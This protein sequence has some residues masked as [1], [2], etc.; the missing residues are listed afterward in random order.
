MYYRHSGYP[1]GLKKRTLD[2][3]LE[4]RPEEVIRLAVRG[5]LPKNRL[6]RK[7][8]TKL[9]IYAGPEHPH[10]A[11]KPHEAG[12]HHP[13]TDEKQGEVNEPDEIAAEDAVGAQETPTPR[14]QAREQAIADEPVAESEQ[15][16]AEASRRAR[17]GARP[18]RRRRAADRRPRPGRRG[19]GRLRRGDPARQAGD[20]RHGPRGRHRPRGRGGPARRETRSDDEDGDGDAADEDLT[21]PIADAAIDLAAG[22]R[23][24][25]TGKRKT[26]VARVILKPGTG[27]YTIN[28]RTLDEFFPRPA[29]QRTIRQAL[30]TVALEEK[31]DVVAS[32]HGGGVSAQA[33]ALRHGISARARRRGP[34]PALRAQA[35]RLPHARRAREGAQEGR[36]QEGPQAAAVL[37]A[38]SAAWRARSSAP[39]VSG[40]SRASS[41]TAEL[42]ARARPRRHRSALGADAPRV[43][44]IRDTRESGEMLEAAVAAGVAA[45]GGEALLGGVLPTPGRAAA[46]RPPRARPRRRALRLAQP[47]PRQRHQVLRRRRLQALRRR[48]AGDR[49]RARRARRAARRD[50]PRAA[51]RTARWRTTCARCTSASRG[52]DLSGRRI[53]L[54]CANGPTYRAAPEIFRRL[55]A[56]V[57]VLA[58]APTAATSTRAAAPRT[59]RR[60]P[61][62]SREGGHDAGFAFDGDGDRVLAVDRAGAVV[63]GD[64]LIALA[65]LHLRAQGRLPGGG[66]AVTVMTNY[67]FHTA[68]RDA[69]GGGRD[70][71]GRRPLRA[72]GAARARLGAGR[73]AVGPH[74][75]HGLRPVG[76]RHRRGAADARGAR[77]AATWPTAHAMEKLPQRLVNVRLADRAALA[78]AVEADRRRGRRA[79]RGARAGRGRVLVRASGTEPL[80]RVMVEAPT[81]EEADAVCG[82]LSPPSRP[83]APRSGPRSGARRIPRIRRQARPATGQRRGPLEGL[84]RPALEFEL[85]GGPRQGPLLVERRPERMCGIV[86]YSGER[87]AQDIVLAGLE[88]LEYRGYDSAGIS[89]VV[90]RPAWTPSAPSAT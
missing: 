24:S 63:D 70:H 15:R 39:T 6:A 28:G 44:V 83:T 84:R 26:A 29:L 2:E 81:A 21:Q 4:R 65:A 48:R 5:M 90:R 89:L 42:A 76:R 57:D 27:A 59:S 43:L 88:K 56:D 7:Q 37:E 87:A 60:S 3:M 22:A 20:P 78:A 47:V 66:V 82:R 49:G 16:A 71:R 85:D 25:A 72:R 62:T 13:M 30:E 41:V 36:P 73:G 55:G 51:A 33:G 54:D 58:D 75:R 1:G 86:G 46:A 9:K 11:Q 67:G 8:L 77:R 40:G 14:Q 17:R 32:M 68:M 35:P 31:I 50:R 34:E 19:R 74:H 45:A 80:V 61:C 18:P 38:L 23:Y 52:L 64:E 12:D 69:G 79:R 10:E 53:A